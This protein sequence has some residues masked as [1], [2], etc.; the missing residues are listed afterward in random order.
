M[1]EIL[2]DT[3]SLYLLCQYPSAIACSYINPPNN[4]SMQS[5]NQTPKLLSEA[6]NLL[7]II[8]FITEF[9]RVIKAIGISDVQYVICR[10]PE[11][12]QQH[13]SKKARRC[14]IAS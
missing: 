7:E 12:V 2:V 10:H 3:S 8:R 11:N 9:G 13:L 1:K 6:I 14:D 4:I 5:Q